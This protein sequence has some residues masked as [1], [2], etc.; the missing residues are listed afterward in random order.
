MEL[1]KNWHKQALWLNTSK[2]RAG[3]PAQQLTSWQTTSTTPQQTPNKS[4][5]LAYITVFIIEG[6][7]DP[8]F[9][10]PLGSLMNISS[11]LWESLHK[12][13]WERS[14]LPVL[15]T[16]LTYCVQLCN[17]VQKRRIWEFPLPSHNRQ[18]YTLSNEIC[19]SHLN[20]LSFFVRIVKISFAF[21]I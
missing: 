1:N 20:S 15:S 4:K 5:P 6:E 16:L 3:K 14:V 21:I 18:T 11:P 12:I 2:H 19:L 8:F 17:H 9:Q 13:K 7:L 10:Q